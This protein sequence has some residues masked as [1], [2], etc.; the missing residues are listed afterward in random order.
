MLTKPE[1]LT[2]QCAEVFWKFADRRPIYICEGQFLTQLIWAEQYEVL[3][4]QS[5]LA[6]YLLVGEE[7]GHIAAMMP[8]CAEEDIPAAVREL[9]DYFANEVGRDLKI[10]AV[11]ETFAKVVSEDPELSARY[12]AVETRDSFDYIYEA[13]KL[14]TL[15]GKKLHK[16]KNNLNR[17]LKDYEGR[18]EYRALDCAN[19]CEIEAYHMRW[20]ENRE[21]NLEDPEG[22]L[23]GEERGIFKVFRNCAAIDCEMGGIYI[24][25]Q[26]EAYSIGTYNPKLKMADIQVEKA[27]PEIRGLYTIIN[28]LFLVNAFPEAEIVNREEDMGEEGLRQAKE[29]Y[30]PLRLEKKFKI[31][32][33][34]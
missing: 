8:L 19:V 14:K 20:V 6:F 27:N 2:P 3:W 22:F 31:Q 13:E 15:A 21:Q 29:S 32:K 16:K 10:Y 4:M 9:E 26:L 7:S 12:E 1:K 5:D 33:R 28:Q 25:G 34:G 24:D 30:Y 11:D 17:F 18:Y 23:T